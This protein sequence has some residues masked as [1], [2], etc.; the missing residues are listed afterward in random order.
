MSVMVNVEE[1]GALVRAKRGRLGLRAA[2]Q[3]IGSVSP[4]TLSRV[5]LGRVPDLDTFMR[6]CR[7]LGVP[8]DRFVVGGVPVKESDSTGAVIA[9]HLR[10]DRTLDPKTADALATMIQLAYDSAKTEPPPDRETSPS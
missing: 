7:W 1:L 5:E 3:E 9:A 6:I 10:A 2:A 4:S 8:P